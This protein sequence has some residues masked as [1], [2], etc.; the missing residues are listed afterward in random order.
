M[1]SVY[2][3]GGS[4]CLQPSQG[5]PN[6]DA[7]CVLTHRGSRGLIPTCGAAVWLRH[8]S[9]HPSRMRGACRRWTIRKSTAFCWM[10]PFRFAK[11]I[12]E[13]GFTTPSVNLKSATFR[14]PSPPPARPP[15]PATKMLRRTP[16]RQTL[17]PLLWPISPAGWEAVPNPP[18]LRKASWKNTATAPNRSPRPTKPTRTS[19][20]TTSDVGWGEPQLVES[21]LDLSQPTRLRI[22]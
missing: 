3:R 10:G 19:A 2:R 16:A 15:T 1:A 14:A 7:G 8:T 12:S 20:I 6:S 18:A 22:I 17:P 13:T 4:V 21:C 5:G 11:R 9:N